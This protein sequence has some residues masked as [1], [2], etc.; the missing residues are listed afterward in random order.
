MLSTNTSVT[1]TSVLLM[2]K[3]FDKDLLTVMSVFSAL[4]GLNLKVLQ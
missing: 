4:K 2:I 3:S 1:Y